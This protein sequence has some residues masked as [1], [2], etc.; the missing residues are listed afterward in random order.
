[1]PR[2]ELVTSKAVG[3]EAPERQP[4]KAGHPQLCAGNGRRGSL[5]AQLSFPSA[6]ESSQMGLHR[7][8]RKS[9]LITGQQFSK[10]QRPRW[11]QLAVS[12]LTIISLYFED[13]L[14]KRWKEWP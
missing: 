3:A 14:S 4:W 10:Y 2:E 1:M 5:G 13:I 8:Q 6:G 12:L 11:R 7:T 9:K